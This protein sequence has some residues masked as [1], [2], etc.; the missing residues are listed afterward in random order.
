MG[1]DEVEVGVFGDL[2]PAGLAGFGRICGC[3]SEVNTR[4]ERVA[5]DGFDA[6]DVV[7]AVALDE[8]AGEANVFG[9]VGGEF[10]VGTTEAAADSDEGA[11]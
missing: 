7:V 1:A 10:F 5:A 3:H 2:I 8:F 11:V 4:F 6:G 9:D